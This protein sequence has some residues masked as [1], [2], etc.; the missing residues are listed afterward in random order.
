MHDGLVLSPGGKLE[1]SHWVYDDEKEE[2]A[3]VREDLSDKALLYLMEPVT[4]EGDVRLMDVF[5]VAASTASVAQV[6]RRDFSF[7]LLQE[8]AKVKVTPYSTEY[9]P[10]GL[11]Y[12]ELYQSWER[13]EKGECEG[14]SR[15]SFHGVG[16]VLRED[17][18]KSGYIIRRA[19]NRVD[20]AIDLTPLADLLDI[21]LRINKKVLIHGRDMDSP[22]F[23]ESV[24]AIVLTG[25]IVLFVL[26][27]AVW[28]EFLL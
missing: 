9:S 25:V 26:N 1:F 2:G 11:E 4:L 20:W 3:Y 8:A 27:L 19:G 23:D 6:F 17:M 7:E 12:L 13:N 10:T 28:S 5:R 16:F 21:P 15:W 24:G 18:V 22:T 14:S